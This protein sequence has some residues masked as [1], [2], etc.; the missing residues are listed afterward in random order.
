MYVMGVKM[1]D[2]YRELSYYRDGG[3][4][5]NPNLIQRTTVYVVKNTIEYIHLLDYCSMNK[6]VLEKQQPRN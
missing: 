4:Y 2:N 1:T 6:Q 3:E 5:P